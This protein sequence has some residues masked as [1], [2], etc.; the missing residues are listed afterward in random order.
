MFMNV[1]PRLCEYFRAI[2]VDFPGFGFSSITVQGKFIYTFENYSKL[3]YRFLVV[4]GISRQVFFFLI[5][6]LLFF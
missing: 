4:M 5:V 2:A 3:I 6:E 1:L